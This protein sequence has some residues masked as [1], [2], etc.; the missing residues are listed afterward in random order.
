MI[1]FGGLIFQ[2]PFSVV[3]TQ[4]IFLEPSTEICIAGLLKANSGSYLSTTACAQ[5]ED[6][7]VTSQKVTLRRAGSRAHFHILIV[8]P[9]I[10]RL[11][12]F[13]GLDT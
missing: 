9:N 12:S 13:V 7:A 1:I 11:V 3:S 4:L 2:L 6:K 10:L 8:F 5:R